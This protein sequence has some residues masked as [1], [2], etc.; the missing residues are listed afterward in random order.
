MNR[1]LHWRLTSPHFDHW[2]SWMAGFIGMAA[3]TTLVLL[4][5]PQLDL[6]WA[7]VL[8]LSLAAGWLV[9]GRLFPRRPV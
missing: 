6:F 9:L 1:L 5:S 2:F 8:V 7:F 3:C 4:A